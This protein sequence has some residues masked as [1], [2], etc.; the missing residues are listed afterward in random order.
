VKGGLRVKGQCEYCPYEESLKHRKKQSPNGGVPRNC[1]D[2][3][4]ASFIAAKYFLGSDTACDLR[5]TSD[6]PQRMTPTRQH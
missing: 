2:G 5:D 3:N 1:R 6:L 4:E